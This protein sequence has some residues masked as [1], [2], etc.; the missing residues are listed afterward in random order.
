[1]KFSACLRLEALPHLIGITAALQRLAKGGPPCCCCL[2]LSPTKLSLNTRQAACEL[3]AELDMASVFSV[4]WILE[5]K[6]NN[7]IALQVEPRQLLGTLKLAQTCRRITV[8]LAKRMGQGA[9]VFEFTD[10]QLANVW[11]TQSNLELPRVKS[12]LAMLERL[13]KLGSEE[14]TL[15]G[16]INPQDFNAFD[17]AVSAAS[18]LVTAKAMYTRCSRLVPEGQEGL[19]NVSF[20][21]T[22]L[23]KHLIAGLKACLGFRALLDCSNTQGKEID[24]LVALLVPEDE[25]L[26]G[27]LSVVLQNDGLESVRVLLVL[28]TVPQRGPID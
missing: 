5:S 27:W 21:R 22:V 8:K 2:K 14:V 11:I 9:L 28:P 20:A 17:L 24:G 15:E 3:Y 16:N 7:C 10:L 13:R 18:D 25:A 4:G 26:H 1:M 19:E 6:R 12:L 23:T